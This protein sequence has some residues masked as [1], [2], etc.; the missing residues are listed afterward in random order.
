MQYPQCLYRY[1]GPWMVDGV[2]QS[3]LYVYDDAQRDAAFADGWAAKPADAPGVAVAA[4]VPAEAAEV[5][6]APAAPVDEKAALLAE[7]AA[8]G[9]T[10]DKRWGLDTLRTKVQEARA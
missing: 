10:V 7:A 6:P 1:G 4:T 3:V 8:L 9:L 5:V 2:P